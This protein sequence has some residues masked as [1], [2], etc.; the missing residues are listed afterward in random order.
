MGVL[1]TRLV[2]LQMNLAIEVAKL[3][4]AKALENGCAPG[5]KQPPEN[6]LRD[7]INGAMGELVVAKYL[8]HYWDGTQRDLDAPDVGP[9]E[10]RTN[11]TRRFRDLRLQ[12]ED[13]DDR[14]FI[15][16]V[17]F[18]PKFQILVWIAGID[19]KVSDNWKELAPDRPCFCVK[20]EDLHPMD[21]LPSLEQAWAAPSL[22]RYRPAQLMKRTA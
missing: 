15:S 21:T 17:G 1:C 3:R 22:A 19:G 12:P 11:G 18:C 7:D 5:N 16:V 8:N 20:P 6:T 9:Y 4:N 13:Y 2:M 10:V 14:I